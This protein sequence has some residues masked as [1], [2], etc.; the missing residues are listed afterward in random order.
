[1]RHARV[2]ENCLGIHAL[3]IKAR[4]KSRRSRAVETTIVEAE[5][6]LRGIRQKI[7]A[8]GKT[9]GN[10]PPAKPFK[11]DVRFS[12]VKGK[13]GPNK[14]APSSKLATFAEN[15]DA[16]RD[17]LCGSGG[18]GRRAGLR[19]LWPQGR[20]GST[21]PFRTNL[22]LVIPDFKTRRNIDALP[23]FPYTHPSHP[24]GALFRTRIAAM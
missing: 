10:I 5:T 2:A 1:M 7:L 8:S 20:G 3:P 14:S 17:H 15:G 21:P 6:D 13:G 11:M 4:K 16:K 22:R 18:I 24:A 12:I 19:I 23:P 9:R